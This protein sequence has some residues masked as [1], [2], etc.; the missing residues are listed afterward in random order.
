MS[1]HSRMV[2]RRR[3]Q[4]MGTFWGSIKDRTAWTIAPVKMKA[5]NKAHPL[6]MEGFGDVEGQYVAVADTAPASTSISDFV[7][8]DTF[9]TAAAIGLTYHGYRRTGSLL[10]ALVYGAFGKY[11]PV[12]A[13]PVAF[14]QGF[15]KRRI[16]TT[17]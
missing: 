7:T 17:E 2:R 11:E 5:E 6:I 13:I 12:I 3:Q 14:A 8:S 15:G 10:W 9:K 16:C 1:I 4:A